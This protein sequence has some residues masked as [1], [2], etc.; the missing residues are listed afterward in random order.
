MSV[1]NIWH[2][3]LPQ[4]PLKKYRHACSVSIMLVHSFTWEVFCLFFCTKTVMFCSSAAVRHSSQILL[5]LHC[6]PLKL[7]LRRH[8][9][10]NLWKRLLLSHL[11]S[12]FSLSVLLT[13]VMGYLNPFGRISLIQWHF[14]GSGQ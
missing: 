12:P 1:G 14:A 11:K 3:F 6:T 9:H 2:S 10:V 7:L 8:G 4:Y 13:K 5:K